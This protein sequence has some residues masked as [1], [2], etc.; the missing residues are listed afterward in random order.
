MGWQLLLVED[1]V[2]GQ[3]VTRSILEHHNITV[4]VA[5]D[6]LHALELLRDNRYTAV[7]IDLSLPGMNGWELLEAIRQ[8]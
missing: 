1:D 2:N 7:I 8:E 4:D 6:A 5:D 3:D